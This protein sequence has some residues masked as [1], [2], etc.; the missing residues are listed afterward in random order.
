MDELSAIQALMWRAITWPTGVADFLAHADDD[1]RAAFARTFAETAAFDRGARVGVYAEA[2]FWRLHGVLTDHF[3]IVAWLLGPARFH[4]LVTDY[5]LACPPVD[6]DIRRYGERLPGF[7]ASHA[8]TQSIPD[9]AEIAALDWAMV[10]ALDRPQA[11]PL[12][13]AD[14]AQVPLPEWPELRLRTVQSAC[15][16]PLHRALAPMLVALASGQAP[17]AD[18]PGRARMAI[19][20]R[21]GFDVRARVA[22]D[23]EAEALA[24][25][26]EGARFVELCEAPGLDA[27]TVAGWVARWVGEGV[28]ARG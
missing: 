3:G 22:D 11:D 4:N 13:L 25:L 9:L 16:L 15:V 14:L 7:V 10:C 1:T 28:L 6:P 5:V 17:P 20:W 26:I 2:Y 27:T 8:V 21:A 23:D 18:P 24:R 19:V 12:A